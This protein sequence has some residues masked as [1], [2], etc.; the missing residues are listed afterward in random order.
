MLLSL[1]WLKEFVPYTGTAQELGA[2]LTM[3]GLE[4]ENIIEPYKDIEHIVIGFV[5]EREKHPEADKLSVCTVDVGQ[6]ELL[7]IVCGAPNVDKGQYVPIAMVGTSMPDGMK[8]KKAKLRN[9]ESLGMICSE[10][11][12]KLSEDHNGI[13]VLNDI[14]PQEKLQVGA[15]LVDALN[16]DK[17]VLEIG[18]TP[19]RADCLSV[20]GFAR[21]VAQ[22]YNLPLTLPKCE[23]KVEEKSTGLKLDVDVNLSPYYTGRV[24]DNPKVGPSPAW[25]KYRLNAIGIRSIS[26]VVDA[27]NYVLM[28]LGLPLHSFDKDTIEGDTVC[29]ISAKDGEKYTTLDSQERTL[30]VNDILIADKTKTIGLGG[31]MGGLNSETTENTKS[32]FLEAAVFNPSFIRKTARRLG[33]SSDASFRFERGVDQAIVDFASER[34]AYLIQELTGATCRSEVLKTEN[35]VTAPKPFNFNYPKCIELL[36]VDISKEFCEKTLTGLGCQLTQVDEDNYTVI[37]PSWRADLFRQADLAEEVI[38]C[39]GVDE[40]P[41]EFP[42]VL[43]DLKQCGKLETRHPFLV[44]LRHFMAGMGLNECVC[45]SFVGHEDLDRLNIAKDHRVSIANPLTAE[46]NVLRTDLAPGL[47]NA[48]K[49]NMGQGNTSLKLF[50]IA[51]SFVQ[52]PKSETTV[53]E[54]RRMAILLTGERFSHYPHPNY[55]NEIFEY[56]DLK[57]IVETFFKNFLN[58]DLPKMEKVNNHPYMSPA[59]KLEIG[60]DCP[61]ALA[62]AG[63]VVATIGRIKPEIADYYNAREYVWYA[64]INL[65]ALRGLSAK[66]TIKFNSL[67]VYPPVRRDI[68]VIAPKTLAMKEIVDTLQNAKTKYLEKVELHDS[69][70]PKG[71]LANDEHNLTFRLT[72][73][74]AEKT[75]VDADVDKEREKLV[76]VLTENL[77]V[78]I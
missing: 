16:L 37:A 62:D 21:E 39:F 22:A 41:E 28:E 45:Y 6:A 48:L 76:K 42:P 1:A 72:F 4:L 59:V 53:H 78:R 69:Y 67:P 33:L 73:R 74:S 71:P 66:N 61:L 26:N 35:S 50:E 5:K 20:L 56:A 31:V 49:V 70:Q 75:L 18:I 64:E 46:Q 12:L 65:C 29:V 23:L 19:N 8:I 55:T 34:C 52:D 54:T 14:L 9:V 13:M 38:R 68:T 2:K 43:K 77:G 57:G 11:E 27:T 7:Q 32:I 51:Q 47:L 10:R 15:K 63:N 30:K 17:E 24:L 40:V 25:L 58:L 36:G 3:L 60:A 44:R